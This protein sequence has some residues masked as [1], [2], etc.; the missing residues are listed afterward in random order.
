[1]NSSPDRQF[2]GG[3]GFPE[4]LPKD[5]E[6]ADF[7]PNSVFLQKSGHTCVAVRSRYHR[8]L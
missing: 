2:E 6:I 1:M 7:G 4:Q 5:L 3:S 8:R